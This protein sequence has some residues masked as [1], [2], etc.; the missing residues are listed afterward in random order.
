V[1][2]DKAIAT[3]RSGDRGREWRKP[4]QLPGQRARGKA[5]DRTCENHGSC[6]TC[7]GNRTIRFRR[8]ELAAQDRMETDEC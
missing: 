3:R 2:L 1:P 8:A 5:V 7:K 6:P 4:F